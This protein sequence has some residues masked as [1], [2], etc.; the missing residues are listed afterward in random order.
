MRNVKHDP[1]LEIV[2][3]PVGALKPY[4]GNAKLHT[5][6][7]IDAVEA[8]IREFGFGN[9][10]IVWHDEA[11]EP[12]IVAGHARVTAAKNLGFTEVP[13]I[14][15]DDLSDA[16]R[17]AYVLADNQTTMMTGWDPDQLA[18]ELDTLADSFDMG[19]FGFDLDAVAGDGLDE[20]YSMRV[21]KV[22]YEPSGKEWA[23]GELFEMTDRFEEMIEAL[24]CPGEIK[25]MLRI[26]SRWFCEF[27]YARIA[28]YYCTQATP[29]EKRVFEA[30]GL[31]L[32]DRDG[33][34][35]NGFSDLIDEVLSGG[36]A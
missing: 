28:D 14:I 27:N 31:V 5:S 17:R 30:L 34:I 8:S 3:L 9:P 19:E 23:P 15:R 4:E 25:E 36:A 12:V 2:R 24:D 13:C 10:C 16:E 32:L 26:R 33:L 35:E 1:E 6:E 21:G 11:G 22:D 18:Y 7:Q 29:D 20:G